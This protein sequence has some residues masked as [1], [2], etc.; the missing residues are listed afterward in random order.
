MKIF[1]LSITL[2]FIITG[3]FSYVH[4][5]TVSERE[6]KAKDEQHKKTRGILDNPEGRALLEVLVLPQT[7]FNEKVSKIVLGYLRHQVPS[8]KLRQLLLG[9]TTGPST[10]IRDISIWCDPHPQQPNDTSANILSCHFSTTQQL[11]ASCY[12]SNIIKIWNLKTSQITDLEHVSEIVSFDFSSC[13]KYLACGDKRG[14]LIIRNLPANQQK[15]YGR[16]GLNA[17]A[18]TQFTQDKRNI[19]AALDKSILIWDFS[20]KLTDFA[21][22]LKRTLISSLTKQNNIRDVHLNSSKTWLAAV[23][24]AD[25]NIHM[26]HT[27]LALPNYSKPTTTLKWDAW[28]YSC[29]R[30]S[31]DDSQLAVGGVFGDIEFYDMTQNMPTLMIRSRSI[32][33][34]TV[35]HRIQALRFISNQR[36]IVLGSH[37]PMVC[38]CNTDSGENFTPTLVHELGYDLGSQGIIPRSFCV[39]P[40]GEHIIS[41]GL[42]DGAITIFGKTKRYDIPELEIASDL[43]TVDTPTSSQET[44]MRTLV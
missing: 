22:V 4:S 27:P 12:E 2:F 10:R 42:K 34:S 32:T 40:N 11:I 29:L 23:G 26:W 28:T 17:L 39:S 6:C 19:I 41:A 35:L 20:E 8:Y 31:P 16:Y 18:C 21:A 1:K 25:R 44:L 3:F 15:I 13:G 9:Y 14:A 37:S 5:G 30:F 24:N 36:I 7:P 33:G 43:A 38:I